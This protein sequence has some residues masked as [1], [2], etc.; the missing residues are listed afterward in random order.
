MEFDLRTGG[1]LRSRNA[2]IKEKK[3]ERGVYGAAVLAGEIV[4]SFRHKI[5]SIKVFP[6]FDLLRFAAREGKISPRHDSIRLARLLKY[7][8][9]AW[10][11]RRRKKS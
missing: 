4:T 8:R 3:V 9:F 7:L 2:T 6:E 5:K 10:R 1:A 11:K